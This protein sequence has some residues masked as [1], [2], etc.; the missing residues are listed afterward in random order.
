[1]VR[2]VI[3]ARLLRRVGAEIHVPTIIEIEE[4]KRVDE[5]GLAGVV[6]PDDLQRPAEFHLGIIIAA[7][8][9]EDDD[10][11]E[12]DDDVENNSQEKA[13]VGESVRQQVQRRRSGM[14]PEKFKSKLLKNVRR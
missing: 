13:P 10:V 6:R 8:A 3:V 9:D 5:R 4:L 7:G 2:K 12:D 14:T 11:E 1:M